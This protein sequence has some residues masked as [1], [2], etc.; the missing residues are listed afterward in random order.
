MSFPNLC[1][2]RKQVI[3]SH[4]SSRQHSNGFSNLMTGVLSSKCSTSVQIFLPGCID[5]HGQCLLYD[6]GVHVSP[7]LGLLR[8]PD[9]RGQRGRRRGPGTARDI[10]TR[11]RSPA[12][13]F[14]SALPD[15]V[16]PLDQADEP[17][18]AEPPGVLGPRVVVRLPVPES[19]V[20]VEAFDL[21]READVEEASLGEFLGLLSVVSKQKSAHIPIQ[22]TAE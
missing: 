2:L 1:P 11:P 15:E 8:R 4:G 14:R 21:V 3:Q 18:L 6:G 17:A 9:R 12:L 5:S 19:P 16:V 13:V 7:D 22:D 20:A 10:L